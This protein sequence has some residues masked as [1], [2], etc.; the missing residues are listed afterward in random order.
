MNDKA[1]LKIEAGI[2]GKSG[3]YNFYM[4]CDVER[5]RSISEPQMRNSL[6]KAIKEAKLEKSFSIRG[7]NAS[8]SLVE[9][10][11][12]KKTRKNTII[13]MSI[14]FCLNFPQNFS[15]RVDIRQR[16]IN[17]YVTF[18]KIWTTK[19][20]DSSDADFF[21]EDKTTFFAKSEIVTPDIPQLEE[22][23]WEHLFTGKN[24]V[25]INDNSGYFR[26]SKL[27]IEIDTNYSKESIEKDKE[28]LEKVHDEITDKCFEIV[29]RIIDVYRFITNEAYIDHLTSLNITNIYF[30][31]HNVGFHGI[32]MGNG[33][34]SAIM[35][36][37]K[38]EIDRIEEMLKQSEPCPIHELFILNAESS[39]IKRMYTLAILESFQGLEIFLENF[40]ISK[41]PE[42]G[43]S[44]E[45]VRAKLVKVWN[46]KD[47]LK[48]LLPE[49]GIKNPNT[50]RKFW[51]K[52]CTMYDKDRNEVMHRGK[53][54][55]ARK[56]REAMTLNKQMIAWIGGDNV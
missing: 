49:V 21:T 47:R 6:E 4:L 54:I 46:L 12:Y 16:N 8:Y 48:T 7:S 29:N 19:G 9:A 32:L 45:E 23:G 38:K 24:V 42:K 33:I 30:V 31:K 52:W 1:I 28:S 17:A 10:D 36:R 41:Y 20:K 18:K 35:N 37:S 13:E 39:F 2:K 43:I 14:P 22:H 40:L 11:K 5:I 44:E 25:K 3:T 50:D 51:D 15:C 56:T 53:E 34:E 27:F 55:D 26:Y